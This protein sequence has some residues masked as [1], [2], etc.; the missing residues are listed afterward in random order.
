M[1]SK[2]WISKDII[3]YLLYLILLRGAKRVALTNPAI[4]RANQRRISP[5]LVESC[6]KSGKIK[7]FAKNKIIIEK[8]FKKFKLICIGEVNYKGT[9][10]KIVILTIEK[11]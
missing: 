6:I 5:D 3:I 2:K 4:Y 1:K 9:K 11:K 8:K 7:S 10:N